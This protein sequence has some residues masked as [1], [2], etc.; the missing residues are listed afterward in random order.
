M[1]CA[2]FLEK[3]T[4]YFDEKTAKEVRVELEQHMAKCEHCLITLN[5]TRQTIEV[6]RNNKLYELP[7]DLRETLRHAV[8]AKCAKMLH[9]NKDKA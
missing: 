1:K 2:E 5:T 9:Q 8:L 7:Q 6:Y 4:D 3:L